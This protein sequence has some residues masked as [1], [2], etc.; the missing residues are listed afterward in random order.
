MKILVWDLP[1]RIFHW[2]FAGAFAI[3]WLTSESDRWLDVH[4]F[5]GYLMLGLLGFRLIWGFAGSRY[6]RFSS[7][8]FSLKEA[9]RFLLQV[10][11]GRAQRYVGH[12]PA[13]SWAI[14]GLLALALLVGLSG[15][16]TL[17][18]EEGQG[19]MAG[20]VSYPAGEF[21]KEIH[22]GLAGA[23][24]ALVAFHLLGVAVESLLQREN[25]A[26]AMVNGRKEGE[27]EQ[28]A[29]STHLVVALLLLAAVVAG[30]VLHFRGDVMSST[31]ASTLAAKALPDQPGW[32][33]ECGSCHVA[34][35]PSLL[36]AR[37]WNKLMA[38]QERHFGDSLGLDPATTRDILVFLQSHAAETGLTEAAY[39]IN[40]SI[41][42]RET[43]LR[44]TETPYWRNK[45]RDIADAAW[46]NPKV[47]SKANCAACHADA[48]QGAFADGAIK[49][50]RGI[51]VATLPFLG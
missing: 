29:R 6:A 3:A 8:R 32:R 45:H 27:P 34:Y 1:T 2:L 19:L 25:L 7:F 14:Y 46:R 15:I 47:G 24:L 42:P 11:T 49:P 26:R 12:N 40:H 37:S 18:G 38:G 9:G 17:G 10:A 43:P 35:H 33:T 30:G 4:A 16:L 39:K 13:G 20:L 22:E 51:G 23:M 28:A 21:F 31:Q 44:I 50:P 5:S 48:E 36:P 41:D